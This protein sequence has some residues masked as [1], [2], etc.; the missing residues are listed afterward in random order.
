MPNIGKSSKRENRSE[1]AS[2][3]ACRAAGLPA[4][5]ERQDRVG[6]V[7]QRGPRPPVRRHRQEPC[8]GLLEEDPWERDVC[9]RQVL[10]TGAPWVVQGAS[11]GAAPTRLVLP[12]ETYPSITPEGC[13]AP[14]LCQGLPGRRATG[15]P[16]G[17]PRRPRCRLRG[18]WG[19]P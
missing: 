10:G 12:N 19:H 9:Y 17:R 8:R 6:P 2:L 15:P 14:G 1:V 4:G 13:P 7:P 18:A 5:P 3:F 16:T 11:Q